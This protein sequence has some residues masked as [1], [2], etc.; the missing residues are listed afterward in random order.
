VDE[1]D[2]PIHEVL[3]EQ[4]LACLKENE[5][6]L[7]AVAFCGNIRHAEFIKN[8]LIKSGVRAI[9]VTSSNAEFNE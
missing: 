1:N 5:N 7:P 2:K 3:T 8:S 9:R 6:Y 4:Y